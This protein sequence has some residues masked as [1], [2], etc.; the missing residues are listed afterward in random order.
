[1]LKVAGAVIA[2]EGL[3]SG[4]LG[5]V[6]A[7]SVEGERLVL[8]VTSAIFLVL[9]GAGLV[10][11]GRGLARAARWSRGPAVLTQ[12]IQLGLAWSF[13]GHSTSWLAVLLGLAAA[14]VLVAIFLPDSTR[15]LVGTTP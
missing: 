9:Y 4:V 6:E 13:W 7:F 8:G 1:V 12:L 5:V 11:V 10:Y 14:G 3:L 15:A 2:A